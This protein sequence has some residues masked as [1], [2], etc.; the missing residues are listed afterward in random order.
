[1]AVGINIK[2]AV[3]CGQDN[4]KARIMALYGESG[5]GKTYTSIPR[6]EQL[7]EG[8]RVLYIQ[9]EGKNPMPELMAK[10]ID[11]SHV[12]VL[13]YGGVTYEEIRRFFEDEGNVTAYKYI[14]FDSATVL[15]RYMFNEIVAGTRGKRAVKTLTEEVQAEMADYGA[16]SEHMQRFIKSI[17]RYVSKGVNF[18]L[19][20]QLG[21]NKK[22]VECPMIVGNDLSDK[23][24]YFL[25]ILGR[26]KAQPPREV[27]VTDGNGN[28]KVIKEF[29]PPLVYFSSDALPMDIPFET[30]WGGTNPDHRYV[31]HK[32]DVAAIIKRSFEV[33]NK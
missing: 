6:K 31:P 13:D 27:T 4:V 5:I 26:V 1:M 25:D 19:I 15:M 30:R 21:M 3:E 32:L 20:F 24:P 2:K 28:Q 7:N 29:V 10:G 22:G 16:I 12:D 9:I 33:V 8:E 14:V 11:V 23:L 18:I 17:S